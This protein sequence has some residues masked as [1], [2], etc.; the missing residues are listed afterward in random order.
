MIEII[1]FETGY[2]TN[3]GFMVQKGAGFKTYR[4][5]ARVWL[6]K[7]ND[8]YWLWDTGYADHFYHYTGS[9]IYKLYRKVTPVYFSGKDSLMA[10]L[11]EKNIPVDKLAG[12]I[13]SHFHADHI[14]G[15]L[16][17]PDIPLICSREGWEKV[18]YLKGWR[19]LKKGFIP[20]LIP[21]D[22][23]KRVTYIESF[24][25]CRLPEELSP[26]ET[27]FVLPGCEG[28]ILPV[29][30]PGHAAGQIGAFIATEKGRVLLASDA[31]WTRANY[32][33]LKMPSRLTR[34]ITEDGKAYCNTLYKLNRLF[35]N[36][37][38]DI[39]LSHEE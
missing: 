39:R 19:A 27:A 11:K 21:D 34:L 30:L 9:G 32:R 26:F 13:I 24:D 14:A 23:E 5:P 8:R 16:D 1:P 7:S 15:L 36:G 33:E 20:G 35:L 29:P 25:S 18:R 10:Q 22:F 37:N 6:L 12:I 17:F 31:A 4:F 3:I 38:T 2:C 28:T